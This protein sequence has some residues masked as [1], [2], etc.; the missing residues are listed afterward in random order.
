MTE[1]KDEVLTALQQTI[2]QYYRV[3]G[4]SNEVFS[5]EKNREYE[6]VS[7]V[8]SCM[9]V[10]AGMT[11]EVLSRGTDNVPCETVVVEGISE[12]M[13]EARGHLEPKWVRLDESNCLAFERSHVKCLQ[14]IEGGD[15]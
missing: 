14:D 6:T 15:R 13:R 4:R 10:P 9:G 11:F 12:G 5:R 8:S 7:D 2:I 1:A 3:Y